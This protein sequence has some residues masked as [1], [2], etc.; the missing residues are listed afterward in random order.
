M[1]NASHGSVSVFYVDVGIPYF[2]RYFFKSVRFSVLVFLNT[3][4]SVFFP[5]FFSFITIWCCF[6]LFA[7][8]G[9]Q[10]TV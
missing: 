7:C 9:V 3:T 4:I 1:I 6:V 10:Y 2:G 8:A 5:A